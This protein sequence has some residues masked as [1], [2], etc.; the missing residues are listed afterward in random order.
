MHLFSWEKSREGRVMR[1]PRLVAV[2][3]LLGLAQLAT[4]APLAPAEQIAAEVGRGE[5]EGFESFI[6][7]VD[8]E[9]VGRAVAPKLEKKPP[10]LRSATKSITSLL[11]GIAID[12][13]HISSVQAKVSDL[14]PSRRE[15]FAKDPRRALM[16]LEDLLTMRSGVDCNDWDPASPAQED[17]MYGKRDWVAFWA[18]Q[19]MRTEPGTAFSYCTGNVI[20]LG[21]ILAVASKLPPDEFAQRY[22]FEPL[23]IAKAQWEYWNGKRGVDTGGHLRLAP[24]DLLKIGEMVLAR[25]SYHAKRVVSESWIDAMTQERTDIPGSGQRYGYL[26]WLD[27]VKNPQL[28]ATKIWWAQG[29][30]GNLLIVLPGLNAVIAV[31]GTRFNQPNALEPLFWLR[32][33]LLP[34]MS[35]PQDLQ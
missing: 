21:E 29:N 8:D 14:L 17:K 33:R 34:A 27:H 25:G 18:G 15:A 26:W 7:K 2:A 11:V 22:L 9:I 32:D 20:A 5:H 6:M 16:T 19:P 31:T 30:G 23:G 1:G 13:G 35:A 10:D 12:R 4:A 24:D 28:P 3:V